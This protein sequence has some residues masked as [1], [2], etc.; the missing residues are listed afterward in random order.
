MKVKVTKQHIAEG[1]PGQSYFCPIA[2]AVKSKLGLKKW[3]YVS[4]HSINIA[5]QNGQAEK[6]FKLTKKMIKFIDS[7][8]I[9]K[10]VKPFEFTLK[11]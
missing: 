11:H 4:G 5:P 9:G 3:V 6:E 7:F 1:V 10:P 2:L 8:D